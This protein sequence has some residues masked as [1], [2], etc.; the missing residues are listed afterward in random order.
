MDITV[1]GRHVTISDRF[2]AHIE[3][4]L[5]KVQQLATKPQRVD[6]LLIHEEHARQPDTAERVEITVVGKGPVIRAEA[7]ASDKYG[8]LDLAYGKLLE[9]LRRARDKR[10]V[11]RQGR[12]RPPS[13]AETFASLAAEEAAGAGLPPEDGPPDV[14]ERLNGAPSGTEADELEHLPGEGLTPTLVR[15]KNFPATPLSIDEAISRMEL[16]GHDFY[17]FIDADSGKS[18]VVY[19]RRGFSYGVISLDPDLPEHEALGAGHENGAS[20]TAAPN[21]EP[22]AA[23]TDARALAG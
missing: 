1:T 7:C 5:E 10:K 9:R 12:H 11:A 15:A 21:G 3:N 14:Q 2:R 13:T 16:V 23:G 20:G 8:A 18:S 4:K 19:R 22:S 17:L 6:V